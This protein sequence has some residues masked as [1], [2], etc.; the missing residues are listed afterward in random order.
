MTPKEKAKELFNKFELSCAGIVSFDDD[1]EALAVL[2][3][4]IA[5]NQ[6][7]E[8]IKLYAD[9]EVAQTRIIYWNKV[10]NEIEKL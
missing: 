6:I 4:L 5:V 2:D 9:E 10:K 8:E 3:S 1:W 7:I